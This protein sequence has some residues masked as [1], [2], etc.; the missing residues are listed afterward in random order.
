MLDY[1]DFN[2]DDYEPSAF[3]DYLV[4]EANS[5]YKMYSDGKIL[6]NGEFMASPDTVKDAFDE[7]ISNYLKGVAFKDVNYSTIVDDLMLYVDENNIRL[8]N[9]FH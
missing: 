8:R 4:D 1:A 9:K 3:R 6:E 7:S 2:K 5:I